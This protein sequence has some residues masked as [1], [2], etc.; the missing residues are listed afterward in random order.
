[1]TR[2]FP[3]LKREYLEVVRKKSFIILTLL[4]PFLM[5]AMM[6]VPALLTVR[7]VG[8]RTI[9]VID[10]T[11]R[12]A[13]A[14]E[15]EPEPPL[16]D[17]LPKHVREA[18]RSAPRPEGRLRFDYVAA[19]GD[20]KAAAQPFLDQLQRGEKQRERPLDG[21]VV[22]P[23]GVFD[24]PEQ[25]LT[26]YSRSS[27]DFMTQERLGAIVNRAV[28]HRRLA[29]RGIAPAEADRLLRRVRVEGVK[30]SRSGE[31]SAG[32]ELN[33]V[34]GLFFM[35]MLM[36]PT[37]AYG[38]EVMR[39]IVQEKTERV[40]E[41]LVSSLSPMSLLS[42]KIL[43]LAA[44]GL[45]QVAVWFGLAAFAGLYVGAAATAVGVDLLGFLTAR[46]VLSFLVFYVL[47]YLMFVCV[48]AVGG[49]VSNSEKE[50][51]QFMA[52]I[53]I[54]TM[55]PWFLA[56]PILQSPDS[57]LAVGLSLV[58]FFAPFA[59]FMRILVGEPPLWQVA[60][61]VVLAGAMIV[62]LFWATAK[63]FRV[64]ILSYGKRPTVAELWRWLKVA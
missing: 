38:Q 8:A 23:A 35:I 26:Y 17:M 28:T 9:A 30:L 50:A 24:D 56:M 25:A 34:I 27:A 13:S 48:Y 4:L 2:A 61:A 5:A 7:G 46:V 60:L 18:A 47:G 54:V 6:F 64:G 45:T 55:I 15:G 21:V 43:G 49:A 12:L 1:M 58:P 53:M 3:V 11:G 37:F 59:M 14:F 57:R 36:L 32:G 22:I 19:A 42:G 29:E 20:V 63:I 62:G 39:G 10:G 33:F 51:Q 16:P 52:P 40:V 31:Q 41:I 44:V